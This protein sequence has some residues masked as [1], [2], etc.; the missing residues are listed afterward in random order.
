MLTSLKILA[1]AIAMPVFFAL[2]PCKI[3]SSILTYLFSYSSLARKHQI[4][5]YSHFENSHPPEADES[6]I[7]DVFLSK[8]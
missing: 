1:V 5:L 3:T 8:N 7:F 4:L 6:L 2:L